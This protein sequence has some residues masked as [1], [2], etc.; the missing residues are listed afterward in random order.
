MWFVDQIGEFPNYI[1]IF[2]SGNPSRVYYP[3]CS[4][5]YV[6]FLRRYQREKRLR[7]TSVECT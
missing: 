7:M 5:K 4:W 2:F 6:L 1:P 3:Y